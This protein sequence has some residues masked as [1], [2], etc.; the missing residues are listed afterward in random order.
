MCP[1]QAGRKASP[2]ALGFRASVQQF[3]VLVQLL[4]GEIPERRIFSPVE[5]AL[6]HALS[7][8]LSLT[9]AVRGGDL[10]AFAQVVS[11]HG[12]TF[13]K[14]GTL[15]LVRRLEGAVIKAGLRR[16]AA[17]YSRI[18]FADIAVRLSLAG[19][20][21]DAEFLCAKALGDGIIEGQLDHDAGTLV[22]ATA[23]NVYSTAEPAETFQ[24]R[25]AFCLD[26]HSESV[27]AMRY[28]PR[29]A[30]AALESAEKARERE[31]EEEEYLEKLGEGD[32]DDMDE[33]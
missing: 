25:I 13:N 3:D 28:P 8:Y 23:P 31:R 10:R 4:M 19:G 2:T 30:N 6:R 20:A 11:T 18:S 12:Q 9:A 1:L 33:M 15:S 26:V 7:P 27:R 22:S 29:P 14:D 24:Q 16:V 17:A 32:D 5:P 21:E